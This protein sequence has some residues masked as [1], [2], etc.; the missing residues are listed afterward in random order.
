MPGTPHGQQ[1]LA[2]QSLGRL[3]AVGRQQGEGRWGDGRQQGEGRWGSQPQAG[4]SDIFPGGER[5]TCSPRPHPSALV[6]GPTCQAARFG[7]GQGTGS[8]GLVDGPSLP[9]APLQTARALTSWVA[10]RTSAPWTVTTVMKQLPIA[11]ML[12]CN[13]WRSW[14]LQ[15]SRCTRLWA[16]SSPRPRAPKPHWSLTE[17]PSS[18]GSMQ[19]EAGRRQA[20]TRAELQLKYLQ[21]R[22]GH[23]SGAWSP[24]WTTVL[25]HVSSSHLQMSVATHVQAHTHTGH[26]E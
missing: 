8:G 11:P 24:G 21:G 26:A 6:F 25:G 9:A 3:T 16:P 12:L 22:G 14:G 1:T 10:S 7:K 19:Q 17:A 4:H 23:Q 5:E 20:W 15:P 18:Q 13:H 2:R